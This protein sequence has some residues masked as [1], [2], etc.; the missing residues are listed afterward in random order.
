MYAH[1]YGDL[2][3]AR[4]EYA[5]LA[6]SAAACLSCDA[7]PCAGKCPHGIATELLLGPAH[8]LLSA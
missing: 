3:L 1:D 7:K 6:G 8:L 5:M 2:R 4:S